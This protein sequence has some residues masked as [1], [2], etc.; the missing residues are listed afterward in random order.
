MSFRGFLLFLLLFSA[1]SYSQPT[2]EEQKILQKQLKLQSLQSE[3]EELRRQRDKA[4]VDRWED[5]RKA[6]QVRTDYNQKI[7]DA[8]A[9]LGQLGEK[10]SRLVDDLRLIQGEIAQGAHDVDQQRMRFLSL[11][12]QQDKLEELRQ[13]TEELVPLDEAERISRY[14]QSEQILSMSKDNPEKIFAQLYSHAI[15]EII[16]SRQIVLSTGEFVVGDQT[17]RGLF[18]RWGG[19][20]A[21]RS[22]SDSLSPVAMLLTGIEKNRREYRW[23]DQL[24]Q[25]TIAQAQTAFRQLS[26]HTDSRVLMP[27]DILLTP[28]QWKSSADGEFRGF[29]VW[30]LEMMEQGGE[31]AWL[32][33]IL[34]V[35]AVILT[36]ER[37]IV[38]TAKSRHSMHRIEA[39]LG[40]IERNADPAVIEQ[41][42]F[43]LPSGPMRRLLFAIWNNRNKEREEAEKIAEEVLARE[44]PLLEKRLGTIA[45]LGGAAPLLGLLGTVVGM[46]QLFE[47]ITRYGTSDPKLLAGGIA[48]A[49][50]T[51]QLGLMVAIPVMLIHNALSNRVDRLIAQ[52]QECGLRMLNQL[53]IMRPLND[54]TAKKDE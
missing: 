21:V 12:E 48:V 53:W 1:F 41:S 32:I 52:L 28:M 37:I 35:I 17:K 46:I 36:V 5:R 24:P 7:E 8:R 34:C 15:T 6:N 39:L 30:F 3:L 50:I 11:S 49:L 20:G 25:S 45:V 33:A 26:D 27:A 54:L 42:L 18:L 31:I 4:V 29:K 23:I 22:L 13:V 43:V 2:A 19:V 44:L 9:A 16:W 51:T 38:L 10:K 14:N 40:D 47:V